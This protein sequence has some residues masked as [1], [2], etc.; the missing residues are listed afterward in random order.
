MTIAK[1]IKEYEIRSYE[2]D[3]HGNLRLLTLMNILQ[4]IADSNATEMGVG[5]EYCVAHNLAWVA[6][7]YH[8][9]IIRSPRIHEKITIRSW[10]S[11]ERKLAAIRDYE[12]IDEKGAVIV[13]ASTMWVLINFV[14]KKPQLLRA[15]LPQYKILA[16]KADNFEFNNISLPD[17][18]NFQKE[19]AV[20]FDDI[21]VN[22]HVNNAVY[23]L[24]ISE[25]VPYEFRDK[26]SVCE[27]EIAFKKATQAGEVVQSVS[28]LDGNKSLHRITSL[29]DGRELAR[30]IVTWTKA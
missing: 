3:K 16:E 28:F 2:C 9:K 13:Q 15:N 19:F 5:Y 12:V 11:E 18:F 8:I 22:N 14:T 24:W 7:N 20:R 1:Y 6:A 17:N 4:D 23:P 30:A 26:H 10:P 21:D 27:L 29:V 25:T